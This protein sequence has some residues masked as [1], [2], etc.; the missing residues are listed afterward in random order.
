MEK[1]YYN[2]RGEGLA[3]GAAHIDL[4]GRMWGV[5]EWGFF[6]FNPLRNQVE[7]REFPVPDDELYYIT[8][9]VE[10]SLDGRFLY[11]TVIQ[12]KGCISWTAKPASGAS[13][14]R[15]AIL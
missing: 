6:L 5:T 11:L 14:V 7:F 8:N 10:E 13:S 12:G 15:P 1:V 2:K 9:G 3:Y 4:L